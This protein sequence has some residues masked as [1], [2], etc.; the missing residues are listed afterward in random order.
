MNDITKLQ[1]ENAQLRKTNK[2]LEE[3]LDL[4]KLNYL[5]FKI[6]STNLKYKSNISVLNNYN[7]YKLNKIETQT[8]TNE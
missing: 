2:E 6:Q 7:K 1:I 4:I 5:H 8:L 3:K